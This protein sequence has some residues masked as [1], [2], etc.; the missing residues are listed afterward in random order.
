MRTARQD[1]IGKVLTHL[2]RTGDGPSQKLRLAVVGDLHTSLSPSN[3]GPVLIS[4]WLDVFNSHP[5]IPVSITLH[6]TSVNENS[7][8]NTSIKLGSKNHEIIRNPFV[9]INESSLV[10]AGLKDEVSSLLNMGSEQLTTFGK[11]APTTFWVGHERADDTQLDVRWNRGIREV[12]VN[13]VALS[14]IPE[15]S[16]RGPVELL[17][18]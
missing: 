17:T 1:L 5:S 10:D 6:P 14:P 8:V 3:S 15:K 2:I 12:V 13:A 18:S 9:P 4:E 11:L 16:P 7:P